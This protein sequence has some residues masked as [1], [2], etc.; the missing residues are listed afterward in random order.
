M[1]KFNVPLILRGKVIHDAD[2][3]FGGRRG[4][5]SF[6]SADVRKHLDELPLSTPSALRDLHQL[7]FADIADFL[8]E[9]GT[10]LAFRQN[11]Y[12]QEAYELSLTTS[13][14]AVTGGGESHS[15]NAPA[16]GFYERTRATLEGAWVRPRHDGYMAFQQA[17]SE[18]LR[19]G[20]E[21]REGGRTVIADL[22]ALFDV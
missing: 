10:R 16:L 4:G 14:F 13:T 11:A 12:L 21:A 7:K 20:L 1:A 8:Q 6:T 22:N 5:S 18:R 17:A 9:V 3:E 19:R 2:V 15:V